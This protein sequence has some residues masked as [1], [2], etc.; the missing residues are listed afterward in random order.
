MIFLFLWFSYGFSYGFPVIFPFS[1]GS[2]HDFPIF[3][4]VWFMADECIIPWDSILAKRLEPTQHIQSVV[5]LSSEILLV[6]NPKL[7]IVSTI[8]PN[9][10]IVKLDL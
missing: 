8:S 3:Q 4:S 1:Y 5:P 7:S 6:W 10:T 2:S 9:V